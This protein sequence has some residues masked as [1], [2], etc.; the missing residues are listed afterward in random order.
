VSYAGRLRR[1]RSSSSTTGFYLLVVWCENQKLELELELIQIHIAQKPLVWVEVG[2]HAVRNRSKCGGVMW[3]GAG[4][5]CRLGVCFVFE[6][7]WAVWRRQLSLCGAL[8]QGVTLG[9][10]KL[11]TS[12]YAMASV[13]L[14]FEAVFYL[15]PRPSL[16]FL[17]YFHGYTLLVV[18]TGSLLR[19]QQERGF[20]SRGG[21]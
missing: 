12:T 4:V 10:Q 19:H 11:G 14:L 6:A 3:A 9:N 7:F 18:N 15:P 1:R 5:A 16:F 17:G 20:P 2:A 13:H 21:L 8:P